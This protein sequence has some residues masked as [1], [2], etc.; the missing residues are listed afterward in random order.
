MRTSGRICKGKVAEAHHSGRFSKRLS[1]TRRRQRRRVSHP[2]RVFTQCS[3]GPLQS[4]PKN[5][6]V[7]RRVES[8]RS[9]ASQ[10]C[11]CCRCT[12]VDRDRMDVLLLHSESHTFKCVMR[13]GVRVRNQKQRLGNLICSVRRI[14]GRIRGGKSSQI[15]LVDTICI[16][17]K[18]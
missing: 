12:C 5:G 3:P 17:S 11:C 7:S 4:R 15:R 10:G 16:N 14:R 2:S 9:R 18:C 6:I 1:K 8:S 13:G